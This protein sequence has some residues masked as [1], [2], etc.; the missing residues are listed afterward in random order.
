MRSHFEFCPKTVNIQGYSE[1]REPIR[2]HKNYYPLIWWI[3]RKAMHSS[4]KKSVIIIYTSQNIKPLH[5][6]VAAQWTP[7]LGILFEEVLVPTI[8]DHEHYARTDNISGL[9]EVVMTIPFSAQIGLL[10]LKSVPPGWGLTFSSYPLRLA[11]IAFTPE[12][13]RKIWV[14]PWRIGSYPWRILWKLRLHPQIIPYFFYSTPI[15]ILNFITYPWR[16]PWF[17]NQ[18]VRILNAIAH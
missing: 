13:F 1:L 18:G 8:K 17:L 6:A 16:I 15:E 11:K 5:H 12:D 10:H 9:S 7:L 2:M 3:L 4:W 14:Y